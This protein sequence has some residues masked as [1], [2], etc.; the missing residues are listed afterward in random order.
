MTRVC[1]SEDRR[2]YDCDAIYRKQHLIRLLGPQA[3]ISAETTTPRIVR[4]GFQVGGPPVTFSLPN[5]KA[6]VPHPYAQRTGGNEDVLPTSALTTHHHGT[7]FSRAIKLRASALPKAVAKAK[8]QRLNCFPL[9]MIEIAERPYRFPLQ[10]SN[11]WITL[12]RPAK[13]ISGDLET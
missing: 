3:W 9:R 4:T 1:P 7:A 5:Q 8:P 11:L 6:R 2:Q 13:L 10:L 12:R